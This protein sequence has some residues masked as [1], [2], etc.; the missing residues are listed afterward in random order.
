MVLS[1]CAR[2]EAE[3]SQPSEVEG[4][5]DLRVLTY[6]IGNNSGSGPHALR[7]RDRAYEDHVGE[8]IRMLEADIVFLQEVLAPP[9]CERT[10]EAFEPERA[11]HGLTRRDAPAKRLLGGEYTVVCD[12]NQHVEC[13]G[14]RA[15][16][17][18]IRGVPLR[19]FGLDKAQT[20]SLPGPACDYLAGDCDGKST[21]CDSESSISTVVVDTPK[22]GAIRLIHVHPTAIGEIC[23]SRQLEQAFAMADDLPTIMGG[24]WNFDPSR[25]ADVAATALWAD[26][27]GANR[28]FR[29]HS[30]YAEDC[31]LDRTSF[32][33]DASLDR[34]VTDFGRGRCHV[35][36]QPRLDEAFEFT[37]LTVG[38]ID[39]YA[40]DCS[41]DSEIQ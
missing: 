31:R 41:L 33:Q 4:E 12:A 2:L 3:C 40:V 15:S 29:D 28:R 26:W 20:A 7:I 16:F 24:D 27:V 10:S 14:V 9:R 30:G 11:C 37:K 35:W 18:S 19:G 21:E 34:I 8:R 38:R 22:Y 17:G 6:N 23:R 39:H 25:L 36:A 1:A 32:G 5:G 13:I